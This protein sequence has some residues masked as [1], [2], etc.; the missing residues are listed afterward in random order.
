MLS[1]QFSIFLIH[2]KYKSGHFD[3]SIYLSIAIYLSSI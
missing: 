3:L 1:I 2:N